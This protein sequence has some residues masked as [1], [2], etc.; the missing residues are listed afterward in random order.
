M[1]QFNTN[2][3]DLKVKLLTKTAKAPFRHHESG[4]V[5][6]D[7]FADNEE[8]INIDVGKHAAVPIGIAI[9]I[10]PGHYGRI[11]PRSGL[12]F[13][14]GIQTLAGVIDPSFR[15]MIK[16]ILNN[17]THSEGFIINREDKIAQ[18][19][20]EKCSTPSVRIVAE[21]SETDRGE[22]GF[23]STDKNPAE[24][25]PPI[26]FK[27]QKQNSNVTKVKSDTVAKKCFF[28]S[29]GGCHPL[30]KMGQVFGEKIYVCHNHRNMSNSQ[31]ASINEALK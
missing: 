18:L 4:D 15:G 11:A 13:K 1:E 9:E 30:Q 3:S 25:N 6:Y 14:Y 10:P 26:K 21:L 23:G 8:P 28:K 29:K 12:A 27:S 24:I 19:I 31:F 2:G 16:V 17:C 22:G 5:G 7:L 20:L